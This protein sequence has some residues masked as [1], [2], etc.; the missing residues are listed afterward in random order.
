MKCSQENTKDLPIKVPETMK[1]KRAGVF[2]L[3]NEIEQ[4]KCRSKQAESSEKVVVK[5]PGLIKQSN[6]QPKT[7]PPTDEF[8]FT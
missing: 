4:R 1:G 8:I 2:F 7:L 3:L 5:S 6:A